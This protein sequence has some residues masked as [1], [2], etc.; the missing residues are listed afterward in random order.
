MWNNYTSYN[1]GPIDDDYIKHKVDEFASIL[2]GINGSLN[3]INYSMNVLNTTYAS[4]G[5]PI[6]SRASV[7]VVQEERDT[8]SIK[9][10]NREPTH[11]EMEKHGYTGLLCADVHVME[12]NRD[13]TINMLPASKVY[14]CSFAHV[15]NWDSEEV[16]T[17]YYYPT[18]SKYF[19]IKEKYP[20]GELMFKETSSL[21]G[22]IKT[23]NICYK[24]TNQ[25]IKKVKQESITKSKTFN[26]VKSVT[27]IDL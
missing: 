23:K 12:S 18:H 16:F 6:W 17:S 5:V 27:Y 10:F 22:L 14:A 26:N 7:L 20:T 19:E 25:N 21:F 13:V 3:A 15:Y 24:V 4:K 1:P 8:I 2:H 9:I 11:Q